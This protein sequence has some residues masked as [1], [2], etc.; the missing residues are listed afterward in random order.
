MAT[1]PLAF[2]PRI[3]SQTTVRPEREGRI[4]KHRAPPTG[5]QQAPVPETPFARD[6][7]EPANQRR[8]PYNLVIKGPGEFGGTRPKGVHPDMGEL[9]P[10]PQVRDLPAWDFSAAAE[11]TNVL[12]PPAAMDLGP[13]EASSSHRWDCGRRS[14]EVT[15]RRT[16]PRQPAP[17][18]RLVGRGPP[19]RAVSPPPAR[20]S[21]SHEPES[22]EEAVRRKSSRSEEKQ[23]KKKRECP[24]AR[25]FEAPRPL[26]LARVVGR[27]EA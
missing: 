18:P 1:R 5:H 27:V 13:E 7:P 25:P 16:L 26:L 21:H 17:A 19:V 2:R 20:T 24:I 8:F 3:R 11:A 12:G 22:E 6:G 14:K 15:G 9:S 23:K 4:G 10:P